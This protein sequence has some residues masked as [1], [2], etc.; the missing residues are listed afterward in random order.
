MIGEQYKMRKIPKIIKKPNL[1]TE[2][3]TYTTYKYSKKMYKD[4]YEYIHFW[5][6]Y[7]GKWKCFKIYLEKGNNL[8]Y[9][10]QEHLKGKKTHHKFIEY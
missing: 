4:C 2:D 10:W 3:T 6:N 7:E 9:E 8:W 1:Y 5:R